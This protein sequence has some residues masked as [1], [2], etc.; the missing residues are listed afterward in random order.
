MDFKKF[1]SSIGSSPSPGYLALK[2]FRGEFRGYELTSVKMEDSD[3]IMKW[4][5]DQ[6]SAL[7]QS[8]PLTQIEQ[9]AYFDNVVKPSFTQKKPDLVLLRLTYQNTLIGYGGLIHINWTDRKAKVSF[10]LE[11]ERAKDSFQYGRDCSIFLNLIMKCAFD[12]L[13][14]NKIFTHSYTH[15][16]FLINSIEASGFRREGMLR[17][18]TKV[19]GQ[20]VDAVIASCL[21][22]EYLKQFPPPQ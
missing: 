3:P 9:K 21:K 22:S 8:A 14:L 19:D 4:R 10:L 15:R 16:P 17:Q 6:M 5:N 2:G 11:T 20:W 1:S 7:R 13:D 12:S 18:D